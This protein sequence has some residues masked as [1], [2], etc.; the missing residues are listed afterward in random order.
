MMQSSHI[1]RR[2][3]SFFTRDCPCIHSSLPKLNAL[4]PAL[5]S[6]SPCVLRSLHNLCS[7]ELGGGE[8][9]ARAMRRERCED[10][11]RTGVRSFHQDDGMGR[12]ESVKEAEEQSE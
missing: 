5:N 11:A 6:T 4:R 1:E 12:A 9:R 7:G 3:H 8:V 10:D 2:P